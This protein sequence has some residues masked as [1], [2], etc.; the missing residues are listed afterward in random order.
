MRIFAPYL[1]RKTALWRG[2]A[3]LVLM[4]VSLMA[5][6]QANVL[7]QHNDNHR[8]GA[9]LQE[10]I[11]NASNVAPGT[12]GKLYTR[13]LDGEVYAQPLVVSGVDIPGKGKRNVVF[14]A[15]MGNTLY[16][17]DADNP[18]ASTPLW[19]VNFGPTIPQ[20]AVQ[21]CCTDISTQ[22]GILSTPVIDAA[23]NTIYVISRNRL[24]F[25]DFAPHLNYRQWLHAIDIR[26]GQEQTNSPRRIQATMGN[27]TFDGK[28][29][30]QRAGLLLHNGF[31]YIA[32]ASHNDCGPYT[33]WVMTYDAKTLQQKGVYVTV[34]TGGLGGIWQ[35]GQGLT[36][37]GQGN[38]HFIVGN[39]TFD[40]NT[41]GPNIGCSF[42]KLVPNAKGGLKFGDYFAPFNVDFLNAVDADL[43]SAGVL[44]LPGTDFVVGGGK[45]AV[46]FLLDSNNMGKFHAGDD[47]N[48][49]QAFQ[50][51]NGDIRGT[52]IYYDSPT[53]GKSIYIWGSDDYLKIYQFDGNQFNTTPAAYSP[54]VVTY[55][56]GILSLSANGKT[57]GSA[58]LW[59]SHATVG[60]GGWTSVPGA[61]RAYDPN[62]ITTDSDGVPRMKE[63]WSSESKTTDNVGMMAKFCPPTIA[64]GKVYVPTF[65]SLSSTLGSGQLVVY[66]LLPKALSQAPTLSAAA[67]NGNV[68]LNWN[69]VPK[70]FSYSLYRSEAG[71]AL[72]LL[73]ENVLPGYV[74]AT[75]INNVRYSYQVVATNPLNSLASNIV[76]A[77][78]NDVVALPVA[79]DTYTSSGTD[80]TKN[81]GKAIQLRVSAK[82]PNQYTFVQFNLAKVRGTISSAK[83]GLYGRRAATSGVSSDS[84]YEVANANWD[85]TTLTW[86]N[87]PALGNKIATATIGT[88]NQYHYWDVTDLIKQKRAAGATLV[89]LA[90]KRDSTQEDG[91]ADVF[92]SLDSQNKQLVPFLAVGVSNNP[93]YP[94]GFNNF[95]ELVF[96]GVS[97]VVSNRLRVVDGGTQRAGS[98]FYTTP[99][100]ITKFTT[101]FTF[102]PVTPI[103]EGMTFTI[104]RVGLNALGGSG[105]GL[106]YG[107][108][109]DTLMGGAIPKSFALKLDFYNNVG[110]GDN[111][112]GFF[113]NGATPTLPS[114]SLAGSG[115]IFKWS[116]TYQVTLT[117]DGTTLTAVIRDI[118][119]DRTFTTASR[120]SIPKI[121]GG[122]RAYVGFTGS[123]GGLE[124]RAEVLNWVYTPRP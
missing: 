44:A 91:V 60:G 69:L 107:Q 1:K 97:T 87:Q 35:S 24:G 92:N 27:L 117:Y 30:N 66:G 11:L 33:G 23:T 121:I 19:S 32:W 53:T 82:N 102:R 51:S 58:V 14:V 113:S 94:N 124:S 108:N 67:G 56:G 95:S 100:N 114:T 22:I 38:V 123:T 61:I 104:Q 29:Q 93:N 106:G 49:K 122:D 72:K 7:T 90:I 4:G 59:A 112:V 110:E 98:V 89:T 18:L 36:V 85:E 31:V 25:L 64:N 45:H 99:V 3:T 2:F 46:L 10:T 8:T 65:G 41:G 21:C 63:L 62:T 54:D 26:T 74:D 34:P 28:I 39:G 111:S 118:L 109:P 43:G 70:A 12:F 52:P 68:Q 96:N 55:P 101:T 80:Q 115:V 42:I 71:A 73:N 84:I 20:A 57:P 119:S 47:S 9:N 40:A 50:A 77:I 78:P 6:G 86:N 16:A 37:D 105:G 75:V 13:N 83:V 120:L 5:N 81:F 76:T 88:T 48:A 15:T 103:A 17:F 116:S 79:Q